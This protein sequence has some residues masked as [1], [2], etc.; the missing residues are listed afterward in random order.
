MPELVAV[1]DPDESFFGF[2]SFLWQCYRAWRK[3]KD[4]EGRG[5]YYFTVSR[6]GVPNTTVLIGRG[7]SSIIVSDFATN[8]FASAE[9]R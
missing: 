2:I 4:A 3:A 7:R 8:F 6:Y 5:V 1:R 9:K